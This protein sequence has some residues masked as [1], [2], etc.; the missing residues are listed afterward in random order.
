MLD[1]M[2]DVK[3]IFSDID[4]TVVHYEKTMTKQGYVMLKNS[5][6][7]NTNPSDVTDCVTELIRDNV[8]VE[9]VVWL[10]Q[11]SQTRC[12]TLKVPSLTLGGGYMSVATLDLI[13]VLRQE[14]GVAFVLMTGARTST[15]LMRRRSAT[16][17]TT[18][19]DV[20]EGGGKLWD[21][22]GKK[23]LEEAPLDEKWSSNFVPTCG[24]MEQL[25]S[26][27][28]TR[29]G[30]LWDVFRI[31]HNE[32]FKLDAKSFSTSFLVDLSKSTCVEKGEK[33]LAEAETYLKNKFV[34]EDFAG[35][36]NV[37]YI[38][39]LGKGQVCPV[40]CNKR[41]AAEYILSEKLGNIERRECV[42][43]FDDEND[44]EFANLCG[45]GFI[46]SVAH[47]SVIEALTKKASN[48]E[49]ESKWIR[50]PIE[51]P[52]G[53]DFAL[54]SVLEFKSKAKCNL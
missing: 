49:G 48:V 28:L 51:G 40:G 43:L 14:H 53:T 4:G 34:A 13:D 17:P 27:P 7:V 2:K 32:G 52:L 16:L 38:T 36:F 9:Q 44:L 5:G 39:N 54:K 26:D 24:P 33:S 1:H 6:E 19:Y 12:P 11:P 29:V 30:A 23:P 18:D 50:T 47:A 42:A 3:A 35:K 41:T 25:D 15:L 37:T 20:C 45:A 46:P 22:Q 21:R 8:A 31:L 10:H